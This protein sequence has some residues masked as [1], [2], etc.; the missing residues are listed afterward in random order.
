MVQQAQSS[1][2]PMERLADRASA[3]FVPVVLA[4]AVLTFAAWLYFSGS[5]AL[6]LANT[7][8]VLVVA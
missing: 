1:R 5:L 4:L 7:V 2:A 6:A 3:I 8:A